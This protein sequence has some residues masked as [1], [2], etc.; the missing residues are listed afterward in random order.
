M[1]DDRKYRQRGYRD[2]DRDR[3]RQPAAPRPPREPRDGPRTPNLMAS[4]EVFRCGRCGRLQTAAFG[5]DDRCQQCGVDLHSCVQCV[6]FD[7][8]SRFEC[9][10]PIAARVSPK[11]G[12]NACV[13]F[14][15][16]T[17]VERQTGSTPAAGPVSARQ[18]FDDLFK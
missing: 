16:R 3:A 17:T 14:G 1:S 8:G 11:D 6:S 12:R 2:D 18:A 15:P 5:A 13:H 7:P 10:Q 9:M 4:H